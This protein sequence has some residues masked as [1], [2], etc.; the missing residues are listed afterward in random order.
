MRP[1]SPSLC[2]LVL[3]SFLLA[4]S[5]V[6][7]GYETAARA[8]HAASAGRFDEAVRQMET[9]VSQ[10]REPALRRQRI[11]DLA[12]WLERVGRNAQAAAAYRKAARIAPQARIW[13]AAGYAFL[14]SGEKSLRPAALDAFEKAAAISPDE[15]ALW[16]QIGY[17]HKELGA[18]R[19][20]L[21]AFRRAW[22]LQPVTPPSG[23]GGDDPA[24]TRRL[25]AREIAELSD[26]WQGSLDFVWRANAPRAAP[27]VLSERSLTSSQI[28]LSLARLFDS[29]VGV[30]RVRFFGR[31]LAAPRRSE[32]LPDDRSLQGGIGLSWQPLARHNLVLTVERLV[33]IGSFARND[34]MLRAAWS[35]GA[36]Y[37]PPVDGGRAWSF[38]SVYLDGA[39]IDPA[40]P[41]LLGNAQLRAGRAWAFGRLVVAPQAAVNLFAQRDDF[42][43]VSLLQI[44]PGL[45]LRWSLHRDARP[46]P[47]Q[48]LALTLSFQKK[49]LG[50]S[51]NN[52]GLS[53]RL[54]W[55]F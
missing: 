16:R 46:Q 29:F 24:V 23:G 8:Y 44:E 30:R 20:A 17:L 37:A 2:L 9:A 33:R 19:E 15:A 27:V 32:I 54:S 41:D 7:P 21:G 50:S 35:S 10:T 22:N 38:W 28:N 48:M 25:L 18:R 12:V 34:F 11:L 40:S 55:R 14:R 5:P 4:A 3:S 6:D 36:G 53:L 1:A 26:R 52:R 39:L 13:K 45:E 31:L 42:G 43:A 49:L 51:R 47:P